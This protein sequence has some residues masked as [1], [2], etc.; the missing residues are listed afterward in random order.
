MPRHILI[1]DDDQNTRLALAISLRHC[2]Y[3]VSLAMDGPEALELAA[4]VN[5]GG[6]DLAIVDISIPG[7][8]GAFFID[9]IKK[10]EKPVPVVV[11]SGFADKAFFIE[12]LNNGCTDFLDR[13]RREPG[14]I[15]D[16][17]DRSQRRVGTS[18]AIR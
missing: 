10:K 7:M 1:L 8:S 13:D 6:I 2:G 17:S 18:N 9:E 5:G 16:I 14:H 12:I 4:S 3:K 11:V 15:R